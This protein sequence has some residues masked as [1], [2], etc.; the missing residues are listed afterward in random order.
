MTKWLRKSIEWQNDCENPLN[1]KLIDKSNWLTK[2]LTKSI[3]WQTDYE[4]QFAWQ[5][6]WEI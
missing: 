4:D 6:N 5:N 1:D 3:E 2:L